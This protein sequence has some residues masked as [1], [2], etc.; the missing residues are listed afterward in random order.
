MKYIALILLVLMASPAVAEIQ[1]PDFDQLPPATQQSWGLNAKRVEGNNPS[2]RVFATSD[3]APYCKA[4]RICIKNRA[5]R[6]V[7]EINAS[8]TQHKDGS[9]DIL[10]NLFDTID[11]TAELIIH[12][13]QKPDAPM[14]TNFGGF[15]FRLD[16]KKE[17]PTSN[18]KG[19]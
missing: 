13:T 19:K 5:G 12:M 7:A 18:V 3:A 17:N 9:K 16:N 15:S 10:L 11:G 8:M 14:Y 6:L 2:I 4:A 1:F